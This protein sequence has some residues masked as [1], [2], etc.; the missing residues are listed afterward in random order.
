MDGFS[1]HVV[2][3]VIPTIALKLSIKGRKRGANLA[4]TGEPEVAYASANPAIAAITGRL[5][6]HQSGNRGAIVAIAATLAA[7][8]KALPSLIGGVVRITNN[9]TSAEFT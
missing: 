5:S 1:A 2:L 6:P 3:L 7:I 4:A 9:Y 8:S